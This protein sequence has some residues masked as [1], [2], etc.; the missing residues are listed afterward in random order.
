MTAGLEEMRGPAHG[1]GQSNEAHE[2]NDDEETTRH[3]LEEKRREGRKESES[4]SKG[5]GGR[6]K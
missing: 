1:V 6:F 4:E 2:D 3:R 5:I